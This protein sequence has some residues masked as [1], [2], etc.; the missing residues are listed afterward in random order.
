MGPP[1]DR[2]SP[3][4]P[5]DGRHIIYQ[6]AVTPQGSAALSAYFKTGTSQYAQAQINNNNQTDFGAVFDTSAATVTSTSNIGAVTG[7]SSAALAAGNGWMRGA[8]TAAIPAQ[9]TV[10]VVLANSNL[11]V[12]TY[13]GDG[14]PSYNAAAPL[15][16][17]GAWGVQLEAGT[18]ATSYIPTTNAQA[19]R[20]ADQIS[21]PI[22]SG[23]SSLK[24][25]FTDGTTQ[26]VTVS[27]GTYTIP[28]N[29]NNALI[30]SVAIS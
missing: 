23:A 20:A 8:V 27:P 2:R 21:L 19:T 13:Q 7:T 16:V 10:Y 25:T 5:G 17:V 29:L 30:T 18:K 1:R 3:S 22:P 28:T 14:N 12:P 26:V 6:T 24:F 4:L 15:K 11:A 9:T